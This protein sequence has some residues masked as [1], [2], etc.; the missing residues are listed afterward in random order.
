MGAT[1]AKMKFNRQTT[2]PIR[3]VQPNQQ[4][5]N[6]IN[7]AEMSKDEGSIMTEKKDS[8]YDYI[9]RNASIPTTKAQRVLNNY[10]QYA[11]P[12]AIFPLEIKMMI[13]Q[14]NSECFIIYQ[15]ETFASC[16]TMHL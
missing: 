3:S 16:Q 6:S 12:S 4:D 1:I 8:I 9:K 11:L 10:I 5:V 13:I 7:S 2:L 14:Y 15:N